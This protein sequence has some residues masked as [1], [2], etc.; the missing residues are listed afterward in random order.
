MCCGFAV[1][2]ISRPG[3]KLKWNQDSSL[4]IVAYLSM[5]VMGVAAGLVDC[6]N[7][8]FAFEK[9]PP[10]LKAGILKPGRTFQKGRV[11][12]KDKFLQNNVYRC[13]VLFV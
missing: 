5:Y 6:D 4:I 3:V 9:K 10:F 8:H 7:W 2:K 11:L 13:F 1:S 12:L